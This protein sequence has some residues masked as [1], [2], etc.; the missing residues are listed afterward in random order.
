[1]K[2]KILI[3]ALLIF[4]ASIGCASAAE[5]ADA[6]SLEDT[7][8]VL[9][10]DPGTFSDLQEIIDNAGEDDSIELTTDYY[11]NG[12]AIEI[13]NKTIT[14]QGNGH[15]LNAS[16]NSRIFN[17]D[18]NS[19]VWIFNLNFVEGF[20]NVQGGAIYNQ[21][22][23]ALVE[24]QF[25]HNT[26]YFGGAIYSD[27]YLF[28]SGGVFDT[29][30]ADSGGA[31]Y[32]I[33]EA[34]MEDIEF[35]N[36]Y[37]E[38]SGG[39]VFCLKA[40]TEINYCSFS[41]N[42]AE[43]YAGSVHGGQSLGVFNSD[44]TSDDENVEIMDFYGTKEVED[45]FLY[46]KNNYMY[47]PVPYPIVYEN[48]IPI[49]SEI[50]LEFIDAKCDKGDTV[51]V[52]VIYDDSYNLILFNKTFTMEVYSG[53]TLVDEVNL[54]YDDVMGGYY[55]ECNLDTGAYTMTGTIPDQFAL[56]EEVIEGELLVGG[57][58]GK[59][60][61][62][63]DATYELNETTATLIAEVSPKA[64]TGT[65]T[66]KVND[67]KYTV[68]VTDGKATKI[69]TDLEDGTYDVKTSYSGDDAYKASRAESF[70]FTVGS[71]MIPTNVTTTCYTFGDCVTLTAT[72]EPSEAT[73]TVTF[74][75][76]DNHYDP[77]IDKG[78]ASYTV[79]GLADG[80]YTV[81]TIYRGDEYYEYSFGEDVNFT[82]NSSGN[83]T[84]S[85]AATTY[86][87]DSSTTVTL[88]TAITPQDAT[89]TV[90]YIINGEE[91]NPVT[92]TNGKATKKLSGFS[93]GNYTVETLYSGDSSY[94]PSNA[95]PVTFTIATTGVVL[96]APPLVKY[97]GGSER[98]TVTLTEDGM[99]LANKTVTIN[100]NGKN[101]TRTTDSEGKAGM[102]VNLNSAVYPVTVTAEGQSVNTTVTVKATVSGQNV[103]KIFRNGT[104]YYATFVDSTGKTLPN[105]TGVEFNING[106]FYTRYTNEKGVARMN[107]NLNPGEYIITAK[108][109]K[110]GEMYT[111]LIT[112][113][114]NIVENNDLTKYYK[115]DSQYRIRILADDGSIAKA[116]V[117]VTFNINGVF[118][119]RYSDDNGY[120]QMR[121]NLNP[122]E[123]IITA[124]YNGLRASNNIKV[125]NILF[126]NN[127]DMKYKDGS[128]YTVLLLD[129]QGNP[130]PNQTIEI[131]I[132]G[133]F[134]KRVTNESG[135]AALN[136]NLEPATYIATATFNGLGCSNTVKVNVNDVQPTV[137]EY[138][139]G[140]GH[141][142]Q[143]PSTATVS[144]IDAQEGD[145]SR[146]YLVSYGDG[147]AMLEIQFDKTDCT[148]ADRD[149]VVNSIVSDG[150][151]NIGN[152]GVWTMLNMNTLVSDDIPQYIMWF[153]D[154]YL[155]SI[156]AD[157]L[158]I[159]KRL[160]DSFK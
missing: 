37:A 36:N 88:T 135:I 103:T 159:G 59:T 101:Y 67:E 108:N 38:Y 16:Y 115:N 131:N 84:A 136:I 23:L 78:K 92:V 124:D 75:I 112:V 96:D 9:T 51:E 14:I 76:G 2:K 43:N 116:G 91:Y 33:G 119:D 41:N 143:V 5:D 11:G 106:V 52:A 86:T 110:T 20:D 53:N 149:E 57:A 147:L 48:V 21:G 158:N 40:N 87:K 148:S 128:K 79:A 47:S 81:Q 93:D 129:G 58:T 44:F 121:I 64:A 82:I 10:T 122:G 150:A 60:A 49:E 54:T 118:Y 130:Y 83:K 50:T 74:Y 90:T 80:T 125:L 107:I 97:Y 153:A 85:S 105:N 19:D 29:N 145:V 69:L 28:S 42:T 126:G 18:E 104:Q 113:L 100:L 94:N 137:K 62:I 3:L 123:Y 155:Y 134:Y 154:G 22:E 27:K 1:M 46:L 144:E 151:I 89:G 30:Y 138:D 39:A 45:A 32:A 6:L 4:I 133:V 7:D 141:K 35:N 152:Y 26:G 157:D 156:W 127:V 70:T 63:L 66:F 55:Y 72:V 146:G 132:N 17:I 139:C 56:N 98:F 120:V 109:P 77:Q 68:N 95:T 114:T 15:T 34:R 24:C 25:I 8:E 142:L 12:T 99:P 61:T 111:N 71:E 117:K 31:I 13:V 140:N 73:G 102:N 65:V 160:A